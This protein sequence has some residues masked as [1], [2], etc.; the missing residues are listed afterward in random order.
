MS[1]IRDEIERI[2]ESFLGYPTVLRLQDVM[3][4]ISQITA[5]LQ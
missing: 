5:S 4:L 3:I 1:Q 2:P